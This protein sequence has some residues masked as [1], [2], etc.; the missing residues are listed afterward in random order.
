MTTLSAVAL[1]VAGLAVM[2]GARKTAKRV[3]LAVLAGVLGLFVVRHVLCWLAETRALAA[4]HSPT[5]S[6]TWPAAILVLVAI[7]GIAWKTRAFQQRRLD[8]MRRRNMHPR[9][10]APLPPPND[11]SSSEEDFS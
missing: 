8:D 7:G 4:G 1:V 2:V 10:P 11:S 3:A 9:R 6:W 5:A